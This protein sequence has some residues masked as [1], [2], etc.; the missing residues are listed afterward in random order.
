MEIITIKN[1]GPIKNIENLE[2]N[3]VNVFMGPQSSGKS[4]IAK[5][6]SNC[7][8]IEKDI[9]INQSLNEYN[10]NGNYR[11][12]LEDFHRLNG[13]FNGNT[14]IIYESDVIKLQF[15]NNECLIEWVDKYAYR[16][17]KIAYIPSERNLIT[18]P[19]IQ[20]VEMPDNNNRSF[21]F[22]W[23]SICSK[24]HKE[25]QVKI[26][27]LPVA[28]YYKERN[29]TGE[30]HII[31]TDEDNPY[32]ILL[33]NASSGLQSITPLIV[34]LK[35]L[36]EWVYDNKEDISFEK[37]RRKE[38]VSWQLMKELT[39]EPL[40]G[41]NHTDEEYIDSLDKISISTMIL[42]PTTENLI[43]KW[44]KINDR[45]AETFRTQFIIEEPE[46]NLYPLTQRNLVYYLL[47]LITGERDHQLT[48]TTHSPYILYA[49]NNCMMGY[50]VNSQLKGEEN[51]EYLA[52]NFLSQKSWINP[53]SVS[54]WEIKDGELQNIQDKDHIISENYFDKIMTE[55]TD[56]Y[57]Q[58]LNHY[59]DEE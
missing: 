15:K 34:T 52:N 8:W 10:L 23:L 1:A 50:L 43:T 27:D 41:K 35:Y 17:N 48:L 26:L 33:E 59:K 24:Y 45:L 56:E 22:D 4:T 54:I 19:F 2:I 31:S 14:E 38:M 53:K 11:K 37:Q 28:Y 20:R 16:R 49:L 7:V 57:Y 30:N 55:L 6:I 5:I 39:L 46:Q 21:L 32:D 51:V 29:G 40:F 3:K 18:L 47:Q 12:K 13:Y 9:A 44:K 58:M 36:T 25:S 42:D